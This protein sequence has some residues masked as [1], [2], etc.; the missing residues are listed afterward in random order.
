[1]RKQLLLRLSVTGMVFGF[2]FSAMGTYAFG[3]DTAATAEPSEE[4]S[5]AE[6]YH[7]DDI[8]FELSEVTE[9]L[10]M[11]EAQLV[12]P[13]GKWV[14][15]V[16]K[17]TEGKIPCSRLEELIMDEKNIHLG[18]YEPATI[19]EEG[20][21]IEGNSAVAVGTIK[22]FFD[23]PADYEAQMADVVVD[24]AGGENSV[25][26]GTV[27]TIEGLEISESSLEIPQANTIIF[28][29]TVEDGILFTVD[30]T[31]AAG[32]S[33]N[34]S[35]STSGLLYYHLPFAAAEEMTVS[36]KLEVL[37]DGQLLAEYN[38]EEI[39]L[40]PENQE[41]YCIIRTGE[42]EECSGEYQVKFYMNDVL[43]DDLT[44]AL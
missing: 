41:V 22:A 16:F 21:A 32:K 38:E 24:N 18:E 7:W 37:K 12:K 31:V 9:D 15:A 1:M 23:V 20:V 26:D 39:R 14:T 33:M 29:P 13:S 19:V 4:V 8:A 17:I 6:T 30:G 2:S 40:A 34:L 5:A 25:S 43:V 42:E 44:A 36:G 28:A 11:Y 27:G 35:T 10:G 3:A